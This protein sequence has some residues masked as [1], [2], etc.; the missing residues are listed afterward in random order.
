[1]FIMC[2]NGEA[3]N[4]VTSCLSTSSLTEPNGLN[5]F[6]RRQASTSHELRICDGFFLVAGV[7]LFIE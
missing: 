1:M 7:S 4:T 3:N 5:F 6:L 2:T